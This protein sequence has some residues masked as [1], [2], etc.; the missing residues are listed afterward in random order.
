MLGEL[1]NHVEHLVQSLVVVCYHESVAK[2]IGSVEHVT[3]DYCANED[4]WIVNE[5]GANSRTQKKSMTED[6]GVRGNKLR[7][8]EST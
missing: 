6:F 8:N 3:K 1:S 2:A 4:V 7:K 5:N